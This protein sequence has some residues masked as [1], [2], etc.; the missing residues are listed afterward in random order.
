[1][2]IS[3]QG[4]TYRV[5][6]SVLPLNRYLVSFAKW[7]IQ[8]LT[9]FLVG[10]AIKLF[11]AALI[12]LCKTIKKGIYATHQCTPRWPSSISHPVHPCGIIA[13]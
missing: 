3:K 2:V 12:D 4:L 13:N 11:P 10:F 8:I 9:L 7:I 5:L 6:E 1:M